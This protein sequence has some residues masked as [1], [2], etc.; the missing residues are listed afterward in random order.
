MPTV[1]PLTMSDSSHQLFT[2][3]NSIIQILYYKHF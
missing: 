1:I 3:H 2:H